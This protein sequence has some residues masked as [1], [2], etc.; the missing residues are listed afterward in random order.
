MVA[1]ASLTGELPAFAA[2]YNE[3]SQLANAA[4]KLL[5]EDEADVAIC[6]DGGRSALLLSLP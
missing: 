1:G 3:F 6:W 5:R 4:A 2:C